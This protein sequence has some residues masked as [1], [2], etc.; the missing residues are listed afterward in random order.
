MRICLILTAIGLLIGL[1]LSCALANMLSN[2]IVGVSATEMTFEG[3]MGLLAF[4]VLAATYIP[5]RRAT[6]VDPLIALRY[7]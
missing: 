6:Q 7:E 4:V 2:L 1:G 3:V 5:A